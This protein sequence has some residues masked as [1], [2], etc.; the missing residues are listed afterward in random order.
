MYYK[1]R[2][3]IGIPSFNRP[4]RCARAIQSAL[5]Q[6]LPCNV[7][8]ADDGDT[9]ECERTCKQWADHPNFSYRRSPAKKLWHN[10]QWVA[11]QAVQDGAEFF[12]WLQDDDL[13]ADHLARRICRAFDYYPTAIVYCARLAMSY[14]NMLGCHWTGNFG[15]KIPMDLLRGQP[16]DYPGL[17]LLPLAYFEGWGMSPAKSFRVGP[18]FSKMVESLPDDCDMLTERL[19]LAYMGMHGG[20]IAD[21]AIAGYWV[22]H[23]RGGKID[24]ESQKTQHTLEDQIKSAFGFLDTLMDQRPDWRSCLTEWLSYMGNPESYKAFHSN[25]YPWREVSPYAAQICEIFEDAMEAYGIK[26]EAKLEQE[27]TPTLK[28]TEEVA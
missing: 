28:I 22:I 3:T 2:L 27:E 6:S 20:A 8:V 9:D 24:N 25:I 12:T 7:I 23:G 1:P 13:I 26:W 19:D 21:P 16:T 5:G 17:I 11:Q 14:D 4:E 18:V 10:W 15:P